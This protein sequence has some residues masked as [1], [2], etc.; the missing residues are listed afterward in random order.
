MT[1]QVTTTTNV[2]SV[3]D[4]L[5][6]AL[7]GYLSELGL[8]TENVLVSIPER[9]RIINNFPDVINHIETT[10]RNNS[11]YLSKFIAACGAGL[12]DAALNFIW[13][14]TVVN[15][16]S[17]VIRF[18]LEYFYDSVVTDSNRRAK[19]K[20]ESDLV[21]IEEW[22]LI[23]GCHVT[24]IL[25]DIGYKHLDYIRDMRNWAS[26]AHP[27]QNQLT[28]FQLVAWLETCINEVIAKEPEPAAV[29]VKRVLTSIRNNILSP[30]DAEPIKVGFEYL[31]IDLVSSLL[32]TLFGM[33]TTEKTAINIR[34][35]IQLVAQKCWSLAP[36]DAKY[37][38]GLKYSNFAANGEV[39]RKDLAKN[40]LSI[41][42][43]LSYLPSDTLALEIS[44]K[45][46][47]LY[48]AHHGLSN[49]YNE[50]PHAKTLSAYVSDTGVIPDSVRH[51]YVKTVVMAK[52]G[53]GYGISNMA[54]T[55]Y[56][57]M[58]N[59]FGE[60]ELKEFVKLVLNKDFSN[61][62]SLTSCPKNF[63][64]LVKQLAGKTANQI[65]IQ[66]LTRLDK[67]T[68][69]QLPVLITDTQYQQLVNS[70]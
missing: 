42:S 32:R 63:K 58:I 37:E 70:Y 18:D 36:D 51:A 5:S 39:A 35:N 31:P 19:L 60:P 2:I 47:N 20:D 22:E 7:N 30:T 52:I 38:C 25:S 56:D 23:R 16:R 41:V 11:L 61:R 69:L 62:L 48:S 9:S 68:E 12:F 8:P 50:P 54:E 66:A 24:G 46:Q 55:Y 29:E 26:A 10:K 40:F 34:T 17:K 49:F 64:I 15:L 27:N 13:D 67:V 53:N 3:V 59:K 14:E 6:S 28:G 65:T 57:Q 21:K 45:I 44:E 1:N 43:G 33:Y 4:G